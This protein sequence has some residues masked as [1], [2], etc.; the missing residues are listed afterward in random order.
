MALNFSQLVVFCQHWSVLCAQVISVES[1]LVSSRLFL[2]SYL[3]FQPKAGRSRTAALCGSCLGE[4]CTGSQSQVAQTDVSTTAY[5]SR[6][7]A[8]PAWKAGVPLPG[9]KRSGKHQVVNVDA[10]CFCLC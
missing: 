5:K 3:T 9:E 7:G 10:A 2:A 6:A 1:S 4:L 8:P